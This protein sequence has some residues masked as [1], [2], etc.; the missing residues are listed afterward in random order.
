MEV[1]VQEDDADVSVEIGARP[2]D[3]GFFEVEDDE[4]GGDVAEGDLREDDAGDV[5]DALVGARRGAL[6]VEE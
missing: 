2:E 4:W 5:V 6:C 1:E 3:E